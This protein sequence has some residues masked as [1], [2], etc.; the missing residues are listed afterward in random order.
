[1]AVS[2]TSAQLL[3][4][5][6]AW[7]GADVRAQVETIALGSDYDGTSRAIDLVASPR[8]SLLCVGI[9]EPRK[10]QQFLVEVCRHLWDRALEFELHVVGR[11]NPHFGPPIKRHIRATMRRYPKLFFYE[12][13]GDGLLA[14]LY[15]EARALVFPTQA[16]GCGLPVLEALWRGVPVVASD[17]PVLRENTL[18]GG[19]LALPLNDVEAWVEGLARIVTEDTLWM[20]LA[21]E[22][23]ARPLP[24][25]DDCARSVLSKLSQ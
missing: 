25:W 8:R 3:R 22:A 2:G 18:A 10:N 4:E 16:E 11:V 1:L 14:R 6:W 17:L 19:C 12:G 23:R 15:R 24:S 5:F 9:I 13:A 7:Q 21:T 20:R